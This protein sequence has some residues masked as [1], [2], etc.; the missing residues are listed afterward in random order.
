MNRRWE[1]HGFVLSALLLSA[2]ALSSPAVRLDTYL[3]AP[4]TLPE[5]SAEVCVSRDVG[6][7]VVHDT[8]GKGSLPPQSAEGLASLSAR[9]KALAERTFPLNVVKIATPVADNGGARTVSWKGVAQE[10]G[11][12]ALVLAVVS[13]V[14][15]TGADQFPL[16][17]T[18]DGGGAMGVLPGRLTSDYALVELALLDAKND[19]LLAR[20]EGRG[21]ATLEQLATGLTSN[22]YPV[23]RQPGNS[24]RIF[25]PR[26]GNQP[27]S[28]LA[29]VAIE[30]ALGQAI[31]NLNRC[32]GR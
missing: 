22:A 4:V 8:S 7:L 15:V 23:I 10:Q 26:E 30:E 14:E 19:R 9:I 5:R 28:I 25:P 12:A 29:V 18:Q 17:G 11:V 16:D 3:E 13:V 6:L 32:A 21:S 24:R 2:C 31:E 27:N 1:I 20:A